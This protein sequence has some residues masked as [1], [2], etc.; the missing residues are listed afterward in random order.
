MFCLLRHPGLVP[1]STSSHVQQVKDVDGRDK[2]GHD[3]ELSHTLRYRLE[4][5]AY[6]S[7][8]TKLSST[9]FR[10]AL[11]K[12]TVSLFPS[13]A[14]MVPGPNLACSTRP[15][16]LKADAGPVDFATSSP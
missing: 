5:E 7:A 2:P 3:D 1:G 4:R 9:I 6:P 14:S 15:P 8:S 16:T 12:V 13:T 10:P 11:S